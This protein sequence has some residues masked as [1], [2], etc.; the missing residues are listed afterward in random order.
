[1]TTV[2]Y[3][4]IKPIN[5][6]I[7][8]IILCIAI[9]IIITSYF[10]VYN[11]SKNILINS[12]IVQVDDQLNNL[13]IIL[14]LVS[15]ILGVGV[16]FMS[17]F[18]I[19]NSTITDY[20]KIS[21]INDSSITEYITDMK[22]IYNISNIDRFRFE[23]KLSI[24]TA[25][26]STIVDILNDTII[27]APQRDW[28]CPVIYTSPLNNN[29]FW[30][31]GV[32]A[33]NVQ[34]FSTV[35]QKLYNASGIISSIRKQV[36]TN[37]NIIDFAINTPN[38]FVLVIFNPNTIF[39][40]LKNNNIDTVLYYN[41]IEFYKTC[42]E[43][44]LDKIFLRSVSYG[45]DV[46]SFYL[47]FNNNYIDINIFYLI[48]VAILFITI[49]SIIF[50]I[51]INISIN[52]YTDAN[53]M[54]GYV[55]HEIRNPL[56]CIKG[57]IEVSLMD[58]ENLGKESLPM[59][60]EHLN[61]SRNIVQ[62]LSH[63]VNDV[64]DYQKLIDGKMLI[65]NSS[66]NMIEF[67]DILFKI[68]SPKLSE[69]PELKY[70]F[71]NNGILFITADESRLIQILLNF[72][73]N[74]IKF[75]DE[76]F[77]SITLEKYTTTTINDSLKFSVKDSGRGISL[78]DAKRIF[79]PYKQTGIIDSLRHGGIGLGLYLCKSLIELMNGKINFES[80]YS[81]GSTFYIIIPII[82]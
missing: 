62:L 4:R 27:T 16:E 20:I 64:L 42:T 7:I 79:E 14:K 41:D 75:T 1:M 59:V 39:L 56:N 68:I 32:D 43:C 37:L 28:Y 71:N 53:E 10:I 70:S 13:K 38:G 50:I 74:S 33:C 25:K 11:N 3:K 12:Q 5:T 36:V 61:I 18:S 55:N 76:G 72:L 58:I 30:I 48:L 73:T 45:S 17:K 80:E 78:E 57:M 23:E 54:L 24:V 60:V 49:L 35:I 19:Y 44:K 31:P 46:L 2:F 8:I 63:I 26:N 21:G 81:V 67:E 82:N 69:K 52:K 66:I 51:Q 29:T 77:V 65:I 6:I 9:V 34:S 40:P 15:P 47:I 22:P